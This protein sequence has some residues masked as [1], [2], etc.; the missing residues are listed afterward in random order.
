MKEF[1]RNRLELVNY[2][3]F[4]FQSKPVKGHGHPTVHGG[5]KT[6]SPP[7]KVL[8]ASLFLAYC[9]CSAGVAVANIFKN[10]G[11]VDLFRFNFVE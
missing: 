10:A 11:G 1:G 4:V 5:T 2:V 8:P 6:P 7:Q 3:S 9:P